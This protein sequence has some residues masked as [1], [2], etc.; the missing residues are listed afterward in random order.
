VVQKWSNS[1]PEICTLTNTALNSVP[2]LLG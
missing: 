1:P 2:L